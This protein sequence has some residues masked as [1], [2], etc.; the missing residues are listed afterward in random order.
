MQLDCGKYRG[1]DLAE[2][3]TEYLRW[4]SIHLPLDHAAWDTVMAEYSRRLSQQ[5]V[6]DETPA[7]R[8]WEKV[9][10]PLNKLMARLSLRLRG[11]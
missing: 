9:E 11:R 4:A 2:I 8:L 6:D 5:H 3:P 7:Q 1:H 10:H